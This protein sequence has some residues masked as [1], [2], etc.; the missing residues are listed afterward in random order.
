M[1]T[2]CQIRRMVTISGEYQGQLH[3]S[4]KHEGSGKTLSTDAPLDNGGRGEDFSPT[5]LLATGLATCVCTIMAKA[6]QTRGVDLTGIRFSITKDM[7]TSLP[8][9]I[10]KLH[11]KLH[12]PPAAR[13]VP[14]DIL[15]RAAHSCPVHQSLAPDIEKKIEFLWD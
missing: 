15:E 13:Q 8:R 1:A 6:A 5:D 9:R 3:C 11:L 10:A 14:I 7:S 4:A 2:P 12:L